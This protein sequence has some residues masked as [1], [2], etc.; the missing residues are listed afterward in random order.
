MLSLALC[1]VVSTSHAATPQAWVVLS[2]RTGI[3]SPKAMAAAADVASKLK[4][5]PMAAAVEDLTTCKA[6]RVCLVEAARKKQA[7]VLVTVEVGA[8]LDDAT[9]RVE[10]LSIDE[11]G[12]SL[13]V[14]DADGALAALVTKAEPKLSGEFSTTLRN[15]LGLTPP[16][17]PKVEP[18]PVVPMVT[19]PPPETKPEVAPVVTPVVVTEAK[20]FFTPG[21]IAGVAV[22]G[23]GA[24][25]LVVGGVFGAQASA[26][27]A[28]VKM[29]CPDAQCTNP[30]AFTTYNQAAQSQNLGVALSVAGGV[31]LA[32]GAVVFLINPGGDAPAA[33]AVVVPVQGGVMSSFSM[34]F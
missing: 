17:Q 26:G 33:S 32:A 14:V 18:P 6:K 27:A 20:P 22:A 8:V 31:A 16:P 12:K 21:R 13:G 2:R 25:A 10:G 9:L 5:V 34:T 30:E 4:G 7:A 24:A 3:T 23:A 11:D 28:K 15:T 19:A 29:L 1:A